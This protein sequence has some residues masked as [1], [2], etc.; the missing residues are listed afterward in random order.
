[1]TASTLRRVSGDTSERP[2]MTFDTVGAETPACAA[3]E[4]IVV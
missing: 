4:A 1:M 3:I 2:L